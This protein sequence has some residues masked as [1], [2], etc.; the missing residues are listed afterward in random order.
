[1]VDVTGRF[2]LVIKQFG[3]AVGGAARL[4]CDA[5]YYL[6][7]NFDIVNLRNRIMDFPP[8]GGADTLAMLGYAGTEIG[9]VLSLACLIYLGRDLQ[10]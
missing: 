4:F 3:D 10:G 9:L 6:L 1:M 5:A 2:T 8:L 7:P